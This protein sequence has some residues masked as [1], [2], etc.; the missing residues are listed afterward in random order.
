ML[1]TTYLVSQV[2]V[3][4]RQTALLS[5]V[6]GGGK[7]EAFNNL[8]TLGFDP[9]VILQ[10]SDPSAGQGSH[11]LLVRT[12]EEAKVQALM[13]ER[14]I[15]PTRSMARTRELQ[16]ALAFPVYGSLS[17][18]SPAAPRAEA[19]AVVFAWRTDGGGGSMQPRVCSPVICAGK[20][21]DM[22][23][24]PPCNGSRPGRPS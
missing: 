16:H 9:H 2:F 17:G 6:H 23:T 3:N 15:R 14:G 13:S 24:W 1:P 20:Q 12:A 7:A 10:W 4:L 21:T 5:R 11:E 18:P 8:P 19:A 22:L